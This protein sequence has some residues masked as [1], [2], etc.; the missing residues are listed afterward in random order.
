MSTEVQTLDGFLGQLEKP[1]NDANAFGM[2][3]KTECL[4]AKQQIV[5]NDFTLK[6]ASNNQASLRNAILNVA[7]IGITL[8]PAAAHAYLV[9]RDGAI[10]LD[11]S[12]RG[13]VK[14]ATDSGAIEWA[15]AVLVYEGDDFKWRGV[16]QEPLHEANVLDPN[17][18]DA[19]RPLDN[20]LGGYCIAKLPDGTFLIDYMTA[21]EILE[22][23]N[24]SKAYLNGKEG[25]KGPWEGKWA[26]EMAKKTLVKRASKSWPQSNGRDRLDNAIEIL[27]AHEGLEETE[28]VAVSDY[29]R[30]SKEQTDRFLE[31]SKAGDNMAFCLW[32]DALP[33]EIRQ[34][35]PDVEYPKGEKMRMRKFFDDQLKEGRD[36]LDNHAANL[37]AACESMDDTG[38]IEI[39][40][41]LGDDVREALIGELRGE[42]GM[43]V[44]EVLREEA[45]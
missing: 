26:G 2:A 11:I 44:Q 34:G 10:C 6:T 9:P 16:N 18:M 8:N 41:G 20:L 35:L 7:A 40:E 38:V 4:F 45:A 13:L 37:Q 5:K 28:T 33:I 22:V 1:F 29:I 24:S 30:P 27:N 14:L 43:Y 21:D 25:K 31:L 42:H 36:E 19:K 23:R 15:K 3:F 12:Y 32:Y 17:R 39:M